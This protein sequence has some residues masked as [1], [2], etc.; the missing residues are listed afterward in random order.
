MKGRLALGIVLVAGAVVAL[1]SV[2]V[3]QQPARAQ[4]QAA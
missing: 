3:W 2:V 1:G 4:P